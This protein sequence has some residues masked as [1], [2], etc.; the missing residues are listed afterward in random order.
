MR[1]AAL[2]IGCLLVAWLMA[3]P[4]SAGD[5][6]GRLLVRGGEYYLTES[7]PT[8]DPGDTIIQFQND[9]E[10]AHDLK[11]KRVGG[12]TEKSFGVVEAE[13]DPVSLELKLRKGAT[14]RLWC[15]LETPVNHREQGMKAKFTVRKHPRH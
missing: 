1:R 15:S 3:V 6:P 2:A 11:L 5:D 14:Y 9:G 12:A 4:V 7:R 8:L 13:A 10:D